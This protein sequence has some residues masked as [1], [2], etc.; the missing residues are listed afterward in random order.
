MRGPLRTLCESPKE[1]SAETHVNLTLKDGDPAWTRQLAD[2]SRITSYSLG[3]WLSPMHRAQTQFNLADR[4]RAEIPGS[5]WLVPRDVPSQGEIEVVP[6]VRPG[7]M[8]LS[9]EL[10]DVDLRQFAEALP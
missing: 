2:L 6:A 9:Y 4:W 7:A 8:I 3:N 10:R 1:V 5:Q